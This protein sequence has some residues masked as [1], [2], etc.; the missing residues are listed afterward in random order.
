[1]N[2]V[3]HENVE[4]FLGPEVEHTP[5]YGKRTLFVVGFQELDAIL[6]KAREHKVTHIFVGAN[7]SFD[8]A[9]IVKAKAGEGWQTIVAG[10]LD[11]GYFVTV[12]YEAHKHRDA[13]QIF[14]HGV[15]Q[16]RQFV[17]LLSVR[18]PK[19]ET[20]SLNL[21]VKIDDV[22]FQATNEGVWCLNYRE[23]TDS[24]RFTPWTEYTQDQVLS[25]IATTDVRDTPTPMPPTVKPAETTGETVKLSELR[26]VEMSPVINDT[27]AGLDRTPTS[28]LKPETQENVKAVVDAVNTSP[29][30]A[31]AAYAETTTKKAKK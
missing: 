11:R 13:L 31:A 19:V 10:L 2:R 14:S 23:V 1:M 30:D 15:W 12:D 3:G 21:T 25:A 8:P 18:I 26:K 9:E 7:H 28:A 22:D 24:N 20:S 16:S 6:T 4:F 5:A 29:A 17:P 27:E